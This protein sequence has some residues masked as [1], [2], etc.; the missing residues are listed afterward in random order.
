MWPNVQEE[1]QCEA[2]DV[3]VAL[4]TEESHVDDRLRLGSVRQAD[5]HIVVAVLVVLTDGV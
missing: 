2:C 3:E 5:V 4:G 1:K